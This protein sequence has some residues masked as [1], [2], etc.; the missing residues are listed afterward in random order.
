MLTRHLPGPSLEVV[1][2]L[3]STRG[4]LAGRGEGS[5]RPVARDRCS[6]P[7]PVDDRENTR[8]VR[9]G[10]FP[11]F[12]AA[13]R[14]RGAHLLG[15]ELSVSEANQDSQEGVVR[16]LVVG[17][18][19]PDALQQ[20]VAAADRGLVALFGDG[21]DG[22]V[23]FRLGEGSRGDLRVVQAARDA[24]PARWGWEN[25]EMGTGTVGWAARFWA[26]PPGVSR[27]ATRRERATRTR[28]REPPAIET[29]GGCVRWGRFAGTITHVRSLGGRILRRVELVRLRVARGGG[30]ERQRVSVKKMLGN[31]GAAGAVERDEVGAPARS[32]DEPSTG[33]DRRVRGSREDARGHAR[34]KIR[35]RATTRHAGWREPPWFFSSWPRRDWRARAP[36]E[37]SS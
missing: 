9:S 4:R 34:A 20:V 15:G 24:D 21:R 35:P 26:L 27:R 29:K 11:R 18:D 36:L 28:A 10:P 8:A 7:D 37:G 13:K 16:T 12:S 3:I 17:V 25:L 30:G 32:R 5:A 19:P 31:D 6:L 33:R 2:F 1:F 14:S 22:W 23:S